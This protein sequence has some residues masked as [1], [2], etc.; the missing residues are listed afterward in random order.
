MDMQAKN[1]LFGDE[2]HLARGASAFQAGP[3]LEMQ[4]VRWSE[5]SCMNLLGKISGNGARSSMSRVRSR[6]NVKTKNKNNLR[7]FATDSSE[8][9]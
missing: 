3:P 5:K 1:R 6:L 2:K 8:N 4:N 9:R 7:S